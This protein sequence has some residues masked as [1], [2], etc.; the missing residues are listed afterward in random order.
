MSLPIRNKSLTELL[1]GVFENCV[2][3]TGFA[4]YSQDGDSIILKGPFASDVYNTFDEDTYEYPSDLNPRF[5]EIG[6]SGLD[7][8]AIDFGILKKNSD[9]LNHGD[10]NSL[11]MTGHVDRGGWSNTTTG[12]ERLWRFV[13]SS[14]WD[15]SEIATTPAGKFKEK[16][17]SADASTIGSIENRDLQQW[18][19]SE[20]K[21]ILE[22]EED[23]EMDGARAWLSDYSA[24]LDLMNKLIDSEV[25]GGSSMIMHQSFL[26]AIDKMAADGINVS[27]YLSGRD[28]LSTIGGSST[29]GVPELRIFPNANEEEREDEN[30]VEPQNPTDLKYVNAFMLIRF[31]KQITDICHD[32]R[33][34]DPE[35]ADH[36]DWR[37]W[38]IDDIAN[39]NGYGNMWALG[40]LLRKLP[41]SLYRVGANE[42]ERS[43]LAD[44]TPKEDAW[45]NYRPLLQLMGGGSGGETTFQ[46]HSDVYNATHGLGV[47]WQR[48]TKGGL[49]ST[50][51]DFE[52]VAS[53]RVS[54]WGYL[55]NDQSGSNWRIGGQYGRMAMNGPCTF[56]T[57][58]DSA[59]DVGDAIY[60]NWKQD[61]IPTDGFFNLQN[62]HPRYVVPLFTYGETWDKDNTI[63][64][65]LFPYL[66]DVKQ[67]HPIGNQ[68]RFGTNFHDPTRSAFLTN[69]AA[70]EFA[71]VTSGL[72]GGMA[73][74]DIATLRFIDEN[75]G[76]ITY[77]ENEDGY[78]VA[79]S[80]GYASSLL[81]E[82]NHIGYAGAASG[83][84]GKYTS[85]VPIFWNTDMKPCMFSGYDEDLYRNYHWIDGGLNKWAFPGTL[86][87]R[88]QNTINIIKNQDSINA[89]EGNDGITGSGD[90]TLQYGEDP[91]PN[92]LSLI[93]I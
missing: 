68:F 57:V 28:Y 26:K 14:F 69:P 29:L 61:R 79:L 25:T 80:S 70:S 22:G 20:F 85:K 71:V 1:R 48:Y 53:D 76:S 36:K 5:A 13:L 81:S 87:Y 83:L 54:S 92:D 17:N 52:P 72:Y 2:T 82:R 55:D 89:G 78:P 91:N 60:H 42:T 21:K 3:R 31:L 59:P 40:H 51:T 16:V 34:D 62:Y 10:S 23:E 41:T 38:F 11:A 93:H 35:W 66:A 74:V 64:R 4:T 18:Y 77:V 49:E 47:N 67:E 73:L 50:A 15:A 63:Y 37:D 43:L 84:H 75:E 27:A 88:V 24:A 7:T 12:E 45:G 58:L 86:G 19:N 46:F 9:N 6:H 90:S 33:V 8:P 30:Y 39:P 44:D 56:H 32:D 65:I